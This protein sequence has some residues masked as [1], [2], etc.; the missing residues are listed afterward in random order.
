MATVSNRVRTRCS[1]CGNRCYVVPA[2]HLIHQVFKGQGVWEYVSLTLC[3]PC[4][5]VHH[6]WWLARARGE[7]VRAQ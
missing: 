4:R 5:V 3:P 7:L 1:S 6:D 2:I